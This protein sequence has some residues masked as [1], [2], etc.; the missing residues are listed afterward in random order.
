M[1]W[2]SE[3]DPLGFNF[4]QDEDCEK[5]LQLRGPN[6][7]RHLFS[8]TSRAHMP[9]VRVFLGVLQRDLDE[10]REKWNTHSSDLLNSLAA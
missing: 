3:L 4:V 9:A 8:G 10:C 2:T 1:A 6:Q 5:S 7:E